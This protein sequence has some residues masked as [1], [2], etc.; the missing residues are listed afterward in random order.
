MVE[1]ILALRTAAK[2]SISKNIVNF[3]N[4]VNYEEENMTATCCH[5][6]GQSV[7]CGNTTAAACPNGSTEREHPACL[8]TDNKQIATIVVRETVQRWS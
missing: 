5:H 7:G 1:I 6:D 3:V 4:I 8:I 2:N